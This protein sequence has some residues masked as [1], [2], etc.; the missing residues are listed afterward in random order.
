MPK[1]L[2]MQIQILPVTSLTFEQIFKHAI[3]DRVH[4]KQAL[5]NHRKVGAAPSTDDAHHRWDNIFT[6][7]MMTLGV[8]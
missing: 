5:K 4:S 1:L 6:A 2:P 3:P 8:S 7:F